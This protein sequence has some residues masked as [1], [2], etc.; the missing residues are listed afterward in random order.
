M[1]NGGGTTS[2]VLFGTTEQVGV[3]R[4]LAEFRAGRPVLISGGGEALFTLPV[5]GLNADRLAPQVKLLGKPVPSVRGG[6]QRGLLLGRVD[7]LRE[8][9]AVLSMCAELATIRH[10]LP[11][12]LFPLTC[13]PSVSCADQ[14][15]ESVSDCSQRPISQNQDSAAGN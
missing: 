7:K 12:R 15:S 3:G 5:E 4:G 1:R 9:K 11:S 8:S 14:P 2:S 6:V 13:A 10:D